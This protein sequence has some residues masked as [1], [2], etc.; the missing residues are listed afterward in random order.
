MLYVD[1]GRS[2]ILAYTTPLWVAPLSAA[3]LGE[4]LGGLRLL[5]VAAGSPASP[6]C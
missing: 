3:F 4:R 2:A 5:A 6:C 1:G